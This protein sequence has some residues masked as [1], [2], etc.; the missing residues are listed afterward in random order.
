MVWKGCFTE[1]VKQVLVINSAL[2]RGLSKLCGSKAHR[3]RSVSSFSGHLINIKNLF[4]EPVRLSH[5][6]RLDQ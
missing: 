3:L 4:Y 2:G 5:G 1:T 6:D